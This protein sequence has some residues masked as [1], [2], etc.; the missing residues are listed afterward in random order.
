MEDIYIIEMDSSNPTETTS[1]NNGMAYV[2]GV[3]DHYIIENIDAI[4]AAEEQD[5]TTH[6]KGLLSRILTELKTRCSPE[7]AEEVGAYAIDRVFARRSEGPSFTGEL[8]RSFIKEHRQMPEG[9][10]W[11][12]YLQEHTDQQRLINCL[13]AYCQ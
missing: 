1:V 13:S 8:P 12:E 6:W 2:D 7:V 4:A 9:P 3:I 10:A 11:V 5:D